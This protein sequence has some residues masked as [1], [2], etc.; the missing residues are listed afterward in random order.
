MTCKGA[1]QM[2]GDWK[3]LHLKLV[4]KILLNYYVKCDRPT[5]LLQ[6]SKGSSSLIVKTLE[7]V[8]A[9]EADRVVVDL[10][11]DR[12]RDRDR[13]SIPQIE[14]GGLKD[15]LLLLSATAAAAAAVTPTR[16]DCI[17]FNL[18]ILAKSESELRKRFKS[19]YEF[20][21]AQYLKKPIAVIA[22]KSRVGSSRNE[23]KTLT[24]ILTARNIDAADVDNELAVVEYVE[25]IYK[26]YKLTEGESRVHDYMDSQPEI[27]SKMRSI[28]ID[29][30]I[31]IKRAWMLEL[32]FLW[33]TSILNF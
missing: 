29:W 9:I 21:I 18:N 22:R 33:E 19:N 26:F 15:S 10:S 11:T 14:S 25:D 20:V 1:E 2:D 30:R 7:A 17:P 24:S 12:D 28:L 4:N 5:K 3:G 31:K 27:N 16:E 32:T 23:V 13:D 6:D 8:A